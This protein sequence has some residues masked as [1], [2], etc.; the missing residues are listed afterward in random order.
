M[1]KN[2]ENKILKSWKELS[3]SRKLIIG[4]LF[5]IV[6]GTMLLKLPFSL[7][8][9]QDLSILD[10]LF[11]IVSAI[12]V[13]GLTVVDVSKTFSPIGKTIILVFIQLGGLGVMTFSTMIF[14]IINSKISYTT[15]ELLKEERNSENVG[16]VTN[17]IKIL[18][19]TVF[20]IEF[21]GA[22][23]LFLEF[24]K[25]MTFESAAYYGLFHSISAFCNA[26]FS[27]YSD[28]LESFKSNVVINFTISY[29]IILGGLG[30]AVI[31]SFIHVIRKGQ[32]RFNLTAKISLT[33]GIILTFIGM[34]LFLILE[35][36]NMET[37]GNLNFFEKLMAAFFQ[38]V[39]LRTAGFNTVS[40]EN[41]RPA[42]IFISYILMFIGASSGSTGGGIKTTTFAVLIFYIIG[43]L[44]KKEHIELFNRRI[45]WEIMNKALAIIMISLVYIS[46]VT[47]TILALESFPLERVLYEVIS[48]FATVGLSMNLTAKLGVFSKLLIIF[49]MFVGRLG[50]LT[51]ALAFTEQKTKSSLKFPK[52][53][54]LV[55]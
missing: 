4:F 7:E 47:V 19:L 18:L 22:V 17:F 8:R 34:I 25:N 3:A 54:I 35:F 37:I 27:L 13:T 10:S 32:N 40:L 1:Q 26:G 39:T 55:G 50:P 29:L 31:S 23:I 48:A 44:R 53:D 14:I 11:T 49:T 43:V 12:C 45:D 20:L 15:R 9:N 30:F 33:M 41:I 16:G 36:N 42:T 6:S 52:E 2:K 28:S 5:A 51:I 24:K 21:V 38:S 46:F